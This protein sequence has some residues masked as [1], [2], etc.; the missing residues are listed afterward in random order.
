MEV[1]KIGQYRQRRDL[2][3]VIEQVSQYRVITSR[4]IIANHEVEALLDVL[5]GPSTR[6]INA[7]DY[8]DWGSRVPSGR[9]R[10]QDQ[11]QP[12]WRGRHGE[13]G[14]RTPRWRGSVLPQACVED[15][16]SR[17]RSGEA[18]D[19]PPVERNT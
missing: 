3:D 11:G 2:R 6:P 17:Y 16:E 8:L 19:E 7:M 4:V 1:A 10:L 14:G 13:G 5:I 15:A 18:V 9:W 12:D